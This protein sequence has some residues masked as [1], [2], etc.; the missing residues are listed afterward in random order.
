[1]RGYQNIIME[2]QKHNEKNI[3]P[4]QVGFVQVMPR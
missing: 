1:M 3:E 2:M 4:N